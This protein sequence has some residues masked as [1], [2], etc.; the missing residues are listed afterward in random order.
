MAPSLD[1]IFAGLGQGLQTFAGLQTQANER[2][3]Q[4]QEHDAEVQRQ[5]ARDA[6]QKTLVEAQIGNLTADNERQD[7]QFRQ[8]ARAAK[9]SEVM[10]RI[11]FQRDEQDKQFE[12]SRGPEPKPQGLM[13]VAPGGTVFDPTT[14]KPVYKAPDRPTP[15]PEPTPIPASLRKAVAENKQTISSIDEAIKQIEA[16]PDVLHRWDSFLPEVARKF[17]ESPQDV[18]VRAPVAD[19]GSLQIHTRTGANMNIREEPRLA[20]F[21]PDIRD[22]SSNALVKLKRLKQRLTEM[23]DGI[24]GDAGGASEGAVTDAE[25]A[26]LKAQGYSDDEI[27]ALQ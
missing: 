13:N 3:R 7:D 1:R 17:T 15:K 5:I 10:N 24:L 21:V 16:H 26:A 4:Q 2:K 11:K 12:R 22:K 14:Q 18:G 6:L 8:Q 25:R 27:D 9:V 23:N 19:V 20:P